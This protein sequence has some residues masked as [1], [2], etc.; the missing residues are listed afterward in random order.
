MKDIQI[1]LKNANEGYEQGQQELDEIV[2]ALEK[3]NENTD[4]V[5]MQKD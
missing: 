3:A 5:S 2:G 4:R 1:Q